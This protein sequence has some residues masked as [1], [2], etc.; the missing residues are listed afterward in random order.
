MMAEIPIADAIKQLT[1]HHQQIS[2]WLS[3]V[4]SKIY[5]L[6]GAYLEDTT[7][8]GNIINHYSID[9]QSSSEAGIE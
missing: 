2:K 7:A 3:I 1:D 5:E 8:T 4:N 9:F 6:E